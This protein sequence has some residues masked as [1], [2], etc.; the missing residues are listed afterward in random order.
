LRSIII[1]RA[2][3]SRLLFS[4]SELA[5]RRLILC[6]L[7]LA[8]AACAPAAAQSAWS[9]VALDDLESVAASAELEGLPAEDAALE[10]LAR[11]RH[12]AETDPTAEAQIDIAGDALFASLARS[13]AQGGS[14]PA[15]ADPDW[16]IPLPNAPDLALLQAARSQGSSPSALLRPLLPQSQD[17]TL[18]RQELARLRAEGGATQ[19][20]AQVRASLERWRWLPRDL[21]AKRLEVR[22]A[23]F[24]LLNI[25]PDMPAV[26]YKVIVGT[27]DDQTPSFLT[28]IRSVTINPSWD[29]PPSIAAELLRRFRRNPEAAE[30]EG[31]EALNTEGASIAPA[32]VDW[33]AR[34]FPYR[35]RQR[36]G[37]ANA[38]GRIRFDVPNPYSIR[39]HDTPSQSL[40]ERDERALSHGCIRVE[41]PADLA[42]LVIGAPDWTREAID[43]VIESGVQQSVALSD[44]L[45]V[46]LIYITASANEAGDIVYADD[47][48]RRDTGVVAALDSPDVALARQAARPR[49]TCAAAPMR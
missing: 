12:L 17:Y 20:I 8:L 18:L 7:T 28:E 38:L 37:P 4:T 21:P 26:S 32:E 14:D 39:L 35:L 31:F 41:N 42:E 46:F 49:E 40:F 27:R 19:E 25:A 22:I 33:R 34:P 3:C 15:R 1:A 13:F 47:I 44:P 30:R 24:E 16:A 45:P 2:R 11:F 29:P 23:Q 10:E 6:L 36:P 9:D 5:M 43:A 48:Y